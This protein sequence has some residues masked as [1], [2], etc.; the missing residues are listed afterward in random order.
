M[1]QPVCLKTN[2]LSV[3]LPIVRTLS[4]WS[5]LNLCCLSNIGLQK[6]VYPD[7]GSEQITY[8]KECLLSTDELNQFMNSEQGGKNLVWVNFF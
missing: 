6:P 8:T 4:F 5:N 2:S 3:I 7:D 1:D